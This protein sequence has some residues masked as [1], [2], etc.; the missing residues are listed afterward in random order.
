MIRSLLA[1]LVVALATVTLAS[2]LASDETTATVTARLMAPTGEFTVGDPVDLILEVIHPAG[3]IVD[4]P[5]PA[6]F[7]KKKEDGSP[8]ETLFAL[9]EIVPAPP[10][11]NDPQNT[12]PAGTARTAW[13]LVIRPFAPGSIS[14]P[15]ITVGARLKGSDDIVTATTSA[16]T[17]E[18]KSVLHD[19]KESPADIK[20]PWTIPAEVMRLLIIGLLLLVAV[21]IALILWRRWRAKRRPAVAATAAPAVIEPAW[22]RALRELE[23]LVGSRMIEQGQIKEFH[24]ALAEI[25]KR[26]LGEHHVFDA[27]DRTSE[28]VLL[29]LRR[30]SA[31]GSV[32]ERTDRFLTHCDLV[33]FAKHAPSRTEIDETVGQARALIETGRPSARGVAA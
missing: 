4:P 28:E 6:A 17:I 19:P 9:E 11:E 7:Q 32:I 18:V 26:F 8:D 10:K 33:K 24:V 13:R 20:G 21:L 12:L 27:L 5:D 30:R 29:D 14:I 23:A 25:T 16:A 2:A 15:A 1:A 3:A 31:P 22:I